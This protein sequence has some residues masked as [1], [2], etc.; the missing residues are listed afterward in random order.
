[1]TP[2]FTPGKL[3]VHSGPAELAR[4]TRAL[5]ATGRKIA[6]V[7]TMGALHD[8]HRAL[9]RH[10]RRLPNTVLVASIFVNPLQFGAGEDFD[11]YPRPLET[12]L[13]V[14]ADERVELVFTPTREDMYPEGATT[15]VHPGPLGDELEG[16]VRPGHFAGVLTV[17]NKLFNIVRPDYAL[18]GEKDY[19]QLTL[20]KRM[21]KDL[22]MEVAVIGVPTVREPDGLAL[23]SRNA[24]LD[25]AQRQAA[26]TLSAALAAGAHV[27]AQGA[28]A[29]I[30]AARAVLDQTPDLS[31]DYLELRSP[32]L[33]PAP[34]D[35]DA[36][37][38]VA[39]RLGRTRLID[40]VPVLLG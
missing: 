14:C 19:Q 15:T 25:D 9:L 29:V 37:L 34:A 32:D 7:P 20:I 36:R 6:F 1:M 23:S 31:V 26:V 11:R 12:D 10:A 4:V 17:V 35:G 27:S 22:D 33:G 39:A 30:D 16:A 38:L 3:H 24:Y 18:F 21:V 28:A 8:G 13:D 40:N 5:R 2:V